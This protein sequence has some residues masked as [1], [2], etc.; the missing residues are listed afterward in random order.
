MEGIAEF[1]Q[2]KLLLNAALFLA[3]VT[4]Y[5]TS[6]SWITR[7]RKARAHALGATGR[8]DYRADKDI[9]LWLTVFALGVLLFFAACLA[10]WMIG[11]LPQL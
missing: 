1:A 7:Y 2:M 8:S 4:V 9:G 10:T 6:V 3:W 5:L 11:Q